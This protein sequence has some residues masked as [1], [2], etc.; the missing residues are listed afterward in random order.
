MGLPWIPAF[1]GMTAWACVDLWLRFAIG[2]WDMKQPAVYILAS[3]RNGTLYIGVTSNLQQRIAQHKDG[4]AEGF[5]KRYDVHMLV[6]YELFPTM[7][8]AIV[9]EKHLKKWNRLWKLK[10]IED[11]NPHWRDLWDDLVA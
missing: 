9:R 3:Q 6:H 8:E 2:R 1:A 4:A 5:S 7:I 10:L 11:N